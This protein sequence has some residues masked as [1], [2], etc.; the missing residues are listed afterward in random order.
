MKWISIM[1]GGSGATQWICCSS[2]CD[3]RLGC[4]TNLH[5]KH[6]LIRGPGSVWRE[7]HIH[8][9]SVTVWTGAGNVSPAGR[10]GPSR[11]M[12]G[13]F[14]CHSS[15]SNASVWLKKG[16]HVHISRDSSL[17]HRYNLFC[18]FFG[19]GACLILHFWAN[20]TIGMLRNRDMDVFLPPLS[21]FGNLAVAAHWA[22]VTVA[23]NS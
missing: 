17:N 16:L 20:E 6:S 14:R 23:V 11:V 4:V 18:L 1:S 15:F 10:E 13:L 2:V 5:L 21:I 22:T 7:H 8:F 19:A 3:E 12:F 9:S